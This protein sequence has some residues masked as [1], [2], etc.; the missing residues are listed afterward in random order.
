MGTVNVQVE[1]GALR[2]LS[3]AGS[4]KCLGVPY[5]APP[6]GALRW[7]PPAPAWHGVRDAT[8]FASSC[9]QANSEYAKAQEGTEDWTVGDYATQEKKYNAC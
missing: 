9:L 1:Q 8:R 4:I 5:A 3:S 2:C 7:R 6:I